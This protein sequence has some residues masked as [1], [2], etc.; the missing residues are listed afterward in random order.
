MN[1]ADFVVHGIVFSENQRRAKGVADE[2]LTP[3]WGC[4]AD[5]RS[6]QGFVIT[7]GWTLSSWENTLSTGGS[8][9]KIIVTP[10]SFGADFL[11]RI[12]TKV[13]CFVAFAILTLE[14]PVR[15]VIPY[16]SG[17]AIVNLLSPVSGRLR[18]RIYVSYCVL[19]LHSALQ[20]LRVAKSRSLTDIII[21]MCEILDF[22]SNLFF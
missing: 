11:P 13:V 15:V 17:L 14:I 3:L 8:N 5:I 22:L 4:L 20:M 12:L 1:F 21:W 18:S 7:L 10:L 9:L 19:G 6:F 2:R 16:K